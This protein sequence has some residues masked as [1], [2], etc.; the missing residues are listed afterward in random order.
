MNEDEM[1]KLI[2]QCS[3]PPQFP[4]SFQRDVW[5]R[6]AVEEQKSLCGWLSRLISEAL[7]GIARPANAVATVVAM[8]LIGATLGGLSWP[9]PITEAELKA[10]YA[11]SINPVASAHAAREK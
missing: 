9:R 8:F 1:H 2:R 3:P 4:A 7:V 6:I 5:Q 10:A 11:V